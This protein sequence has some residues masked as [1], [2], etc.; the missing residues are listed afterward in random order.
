ML[1][2]TLVIMINALPS[3]KK[4]QARVDRTDALGISGEDFFP[5]WSPDGKKISFISQ[6][7]G[8]NDIYIMNPD[9]TGETKLTAGPPNHDWVSWSPD[10]K[11]I[12][13]SSDRDGNREIYI[14]N[15]DGTSQTRMTD[16]PADDWNPIW[17]PDGNKIAFIYAYSWSSNNA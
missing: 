1:C 12:A 10:S 2:F 4:D 15:A 8:N 3:C 11:K 5:I 7:Y 17:S 9:G 14:M 16:N 13:F 6:R